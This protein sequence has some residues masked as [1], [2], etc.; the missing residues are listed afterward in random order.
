VVGAA[1]SHSLPSREEY[2]REWS[3]LHGGADTRGFVGR[4]IGG[5]YRLARPLARAGAGPDVVTLLGLAA[6]LAAPLTVWGVTAWGRPHGGRWL[7][8]ASFLVAVS[9]LL[10][11]LDGA[12]AL[13]T[14]R[15]SRRG[16]VL[17]SVCDRLADGAYCVALWFAGAPGPLVVVGGAA[18]WLH[19]YVRARAAVAGMPQIGVITVSERPTRVIVSAM[20]L[21][22]AGLYPR[23]ATGWATAGASALAVI[24]AAGAGQLAVTVARRLR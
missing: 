21:L 24:G 14:R 11:N 1:L 10:D 9:G 7:L 2:L 15:A 3:A 6:A 18:A 13:L 23:A 22:G 17:D 20:F 5:A 8:A 4:W 16:F 19:E 12:V